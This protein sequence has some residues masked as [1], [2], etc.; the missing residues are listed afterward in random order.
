MHSVSPYPSTALAAWQLAL[1]AVVALSGVAFWL[2]AVFF[3]A[4]EPR[5]R[6]HAA[7]SHSPVQGEALSQPPAAAAPAPTPRAAA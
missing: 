5:A 7:A 3:A 4:R 1:I 2:G 6:D